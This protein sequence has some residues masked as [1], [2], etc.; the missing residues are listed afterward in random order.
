MTMDPLLVR[1]GDTLVVALA[2]AETEA[3]LREFTSRL[4]EA[5]PG[6]RVVVLEGVAGLAAFRPGPPE[7]P[8]VGRDGGTV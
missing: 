6:I 3:T 1:S 2:H 8:A 5:L 7:T 4:K